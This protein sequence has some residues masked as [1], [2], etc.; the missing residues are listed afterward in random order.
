MKTID[1]I[2]NKIERLPKGYVFTYKDFIN[3]VNSKES[4]VKALNRLV[5]SGKIEKLSKGKFYKVKNTVFGKLKPDVDQV[6]KDL[7]EKDGKVIGYITGYGIYNQLGF[8]T[9]VANTI[10]IA[11]NDVRPAIK[12]GIYKISFIKQKNNITKE[13][14]YLLQILDVIKNI[15]KIPDSSIDN[16]VKRLLTIINELPKDKYITLLRLSIKYPPSTRALLG[17]LLETIDKE[18][19]LTKLRSSLNPISN[20][21]INISDNILPTKK[22]WNIV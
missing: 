9:Q 5:A 19:D 21:D 2:I 1:F 12:R 13:N 17:S 16:S 6:V 18:I 10:Q 11:K 3:Q 14:I 8:T 4:I 7:L 22:N 15:K 20:Y